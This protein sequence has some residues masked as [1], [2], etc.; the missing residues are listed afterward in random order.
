LF[1]V[2]FVRHSVPTAFGVGTIVTLVKDKSK[3]LNDIDNYSP[4]TL[5]PVIYKIF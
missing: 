1:R 5:I 4:I 3:N 2:I